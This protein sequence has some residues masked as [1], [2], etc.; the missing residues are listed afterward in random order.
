M[1]EKLGFP[2]VIFVIACLIIAQVLQIY[3]AVHAQLS[4]EPLSPLNE[5]Y[6]FYIYHV[7]A[8]LII[9]ILIWIEKNNLEKFHLDK[10]TLFIFI[11][12]C[13]FRTRY[14]MDGEIYFLVIIGF[15]GLLVILVLFPIWSKIPKTEFKWVWIA[16]LL[17]LLA[18]I[19]ISNIDLSQFD[20]A[21]NRSI[22]LPN[23]FRGITRQTIAELSFSIP[24][25][26]IIFRGFLWGY[27]CRLGWSN[28]KAAWTQGILFWLVH[29]FRYTT[30]PLTFLISVPLLTF[31]STLLVLRSKQ[32][33]PSLVS[34]TL[35]NVIIPMLAVVT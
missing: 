8:H 13:F 24:V 32:I 10:P 2:F 28:N 3:F 27:L 7:V 15:S 34:H 14:Q 22:F 12:S 21:L 19:P 20:T 6:P 1:R 5:L 17:A 35:I 26:E 11:L 33:F 30:L 4:M 25:E 16:V 18:L 31:V 23:I 29:F 9:A